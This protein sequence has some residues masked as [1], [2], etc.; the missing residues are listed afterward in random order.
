MRDRLADSLFDIIRLCLRSSTTGE[1]WFRSL[2]VREEF[3]FEGLSWLGFGPS[4]PELESRG[5]GGVSTAGKR[6]GQSQ[7]GNPFP[8]E[9]NGL[10][11]MGSDGSMA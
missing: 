7:G 9:R 3:E 10:S 2:E 4:E 6:S 11:R 8:K 1:A 5:L